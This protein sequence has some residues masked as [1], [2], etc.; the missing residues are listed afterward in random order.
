MMLDQFYRQV[1]LE[2]FQHRRHFEELSG[3]SIQSVHYKNPTCGDVMTLYLEIKDNQISQIS[4]LGEG[5]IISMASA[6]MMTKL[7]QNQSIDTVK[8]LRQSMETMI[9]TGHIDDAFQDD[10]ISALQG[11]HALRARH[12]CALMPWQALD[13]ILNEQPLSQT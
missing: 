8:E 3:E 10:E 11:V 5:C 12:N 1:L 9:R 13:R 6:S 4:F 7:L 2:H